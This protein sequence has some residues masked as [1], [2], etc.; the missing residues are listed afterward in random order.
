MNN[1]Y[2]LPAYLLGGFLYFWKCRQSQLEQGVN[3]KYAWKMAVKDWM[4]TSMQ[5]K[6]EL[7]ALT[8]KYLRPLDDG[9][10]NVD[11][12]Q[13]TVSELATDGVVFQVPVDGIM[14]SNSL[15]TSSGYK[16][17]I[18]SS[19]FSSAAAA[20]ND[21]DEDD[22][23]D[24]NDNVSNND[25]SSF[26]V[27]TTFDQLTMLAMPGSRY[28][29]ISPLTNNQNNDELM[30]VDE[31][32]NLEANAR[33]LQW[34]NNVASIQTSPLLPSYDGNT[35]DLNSHSIANTPCQVPTITHTVEPLRPA[36]ASVASAFPLP[37]R[38]SMAQVT[39]F[40][41]LFYHGN[42]ASSSSSSLFSHTTCYAHEVLHR[43]S[44]YLRTSLS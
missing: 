1:C 8:H 25:D 14:E 13:N 4:E 5:T 35:L 33:I 24:D 43:N 18:S 37:S 12:F 22:D 11:E 31:S 9:F 19:S 30:Y 23:N 10:V 6:F 7:Q 29:P 41:I 38:V 32:P 40:S 21:N 15:A 3:L 17:R 36:R 26:V 39:N 34:A 2:A 20:D 44:N 42:A 27:P 16:G 28:P